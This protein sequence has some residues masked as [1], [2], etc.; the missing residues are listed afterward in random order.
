MSD[1]NFPYINRIRTDMKHDPPPEYKYRY[2]KRKRSAPAETCKGRPL[3]ESTYGQM[4]YQSA[5]QTVSSS[6]KAS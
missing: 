1:I 2:K 6:C 5:F 3:K 4:K